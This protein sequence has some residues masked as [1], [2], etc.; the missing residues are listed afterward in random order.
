MLIEEG[1]KIKWQHVKGHAGIEGNEEA[2]KLA[3]A[4]ARMDL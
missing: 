1:I 3:V 4:G 2:D